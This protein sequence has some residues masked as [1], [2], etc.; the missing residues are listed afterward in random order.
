MIA[1]IFGPQQNQDC[2][3]IWTLPK[4]RLQSY[5]N[6]IET[7]IAVIFGPQHVRYCTHNWTPL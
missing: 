5:M 3:H 4:P 6:P 7:K 2:S 1:V